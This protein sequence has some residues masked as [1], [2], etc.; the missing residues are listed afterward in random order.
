MPCLR[1]DL[2]LQV[3]LVSYPTYLTYPTYP[4]SDSSHWPLG[5]HNPENLE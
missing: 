3:P 2:S 5:S 1:P 4:M